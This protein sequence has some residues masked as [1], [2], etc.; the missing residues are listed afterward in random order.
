MAEG[1]TGIQ[2]PFSKLLQLVID[3]NINLHIYIV[4]FKSMCVSVY[5]CVCMHVPMHA[6]STFLNETFK[7]TCEQILKSM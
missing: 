3:A 4:A 6:C 5:V 7:P 1:H 2:L